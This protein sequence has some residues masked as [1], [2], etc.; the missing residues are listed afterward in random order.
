MHRPL[1]HSS[2]LLTA[3]TVL[4]SGCGASSEP[5]PESVG[6]AEEQIAGG[7]VDK[8]DSFVVGIYD[9]SASLPQRQKRRSSPPEVGDCN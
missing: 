9:Q 1:A 7:Y 4:V 3:L 6:A 8:N 5:A 2:A